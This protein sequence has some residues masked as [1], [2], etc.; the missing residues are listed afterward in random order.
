[1][2]VDTIFAYGDHEEVVII[3]RVDRDSV[4]D[5]C[6]TPEYPYSINAIYPPRIRPYMS[7]V[8]REAPEHTA[9]CFRP[10]EECIQEPEHQQYQASSPPPQEPEHQQYQASSS[11]PPLPPLPLPLR[12]VSPPS[13]IPFRFPTPTL[14]FHYSFSEASIHDS[15]MEIDSPPPPPPLDTYTQTP[16]LCGFVNTITLDSN[17]CLADDEL[18]VDMDIDIDAEQQAPTPLRRST[19]V[20]N[21]PLR[22]QDFESDHFRHAY[23]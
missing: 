5:T 19:R 20:R 18:T 8:Q 1:M 16:V 9:M 6:V 12:S 21:P 15:D 7:R 2:P 4:I 22:F 14:T 3:A 17:S 10:Q 11:P 23:D 13:P